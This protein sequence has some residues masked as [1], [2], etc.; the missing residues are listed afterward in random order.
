[1]RARQ[2]RTRFQRGDQ[3]R[4]VVIWEVGGVVRLQ[5]VE[6][7]VGLLARDR[8]RVRVRVRVR[9][10]VRVRVRVGLGLG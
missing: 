10:G 2:G 3:L 4:L 9:F 5:V 8:V 7:A 6:Q 1:M